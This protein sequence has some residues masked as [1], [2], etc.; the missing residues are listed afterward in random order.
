MSGSYSGRM[1]DLHH[2]SKLRLTQDGEGRYYVQ[3]YFDGKRY[4]FSQGSAIGVTIKP[5]ST[6][7]SQRKILALELLKAYRL[8]LDSGWNPDHDEEQQT[9]GDALDAFKPLDTLSAGYRAELQNTLIR[10]QSYIK[11]KRLEGVR[12]ESLKR[13]H[14]IAYLNTQKRNPSLFNHERARLSSI[15]GTILEPHELP[16]P[17]HQIK[18]MKIKQSMHKPF[19]DVHAVLEDIRSFN[20]KLFL[21][22]LLTYGCLLRPHHEIRNLTWGDFSEDL[23]QV[24]LSGKRNKSG[25]NRVVPV[26]HTIKEHL[27]GGER[28][29][30][31]FTDAPEPF[32]PYY[33]KTLWSRY[34]E[35]T[36]ILEPYQTMYSFR[37]TGAIH[38]FKKT[39]SLQI[40]QQVMGHANMQVTLGYLRNL[41]VVE[42]TED[43]MPSL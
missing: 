35:Q 38:V 42:L 6:E 37:H 36:E 7:G 24:S 14:F 17:L 10:F 32:N 25:R 13:M 26:L 3:F 8:A 22:C 1:V 15:M 30:N 31:I 18:R 12:L 33:F 11:K 39:G 29:H 43:M 16:N 40:L 9:L 34:K 5:N 19:E 21:C 4:R 28:H 20:D 41:E 23:S 2:Y 27:A